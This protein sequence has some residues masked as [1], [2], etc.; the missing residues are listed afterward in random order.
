MHT[1]KTEAFLRKA[2]LFWNSLLSPADGLGGWNSSGC[3]VEETTVNYTICQCDHLTH[4]GVL[5]VSC[6]LLTPQ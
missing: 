6:L 2:E 4:F 5:M 1:M 3:E